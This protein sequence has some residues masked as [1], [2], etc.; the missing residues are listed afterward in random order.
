MTKREIKL[1]YLPII[2]Y[3]YQIPNPS[4]GGH[5]KKKTEEPKEDGCNKDSAPV[6]T[7]DDILKAVQD[8]IKPLVMEAVKECLGIKEDKKPTVEGSELDS[9]IKGNEASNYDYASFLD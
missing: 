9:A 7:Q 5:K 8:S 2:V 6:M 1:D 3:T 4:S